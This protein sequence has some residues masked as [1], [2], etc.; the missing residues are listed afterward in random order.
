VVCWVPLGGIA[1]SCVGFI[2]SGER[3]TLT[4]PRPWR[5]S[6]AEQDARDTG[7]VTEVMRLISREKPGKVEK[8]GENLGKNNGV[9]V[10]Y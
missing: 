3:R 7:E 9:M 2:R 4:L 6:E 5:N 1:G 8:K 10:V